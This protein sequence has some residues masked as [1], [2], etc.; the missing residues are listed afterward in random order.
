M[1][2][3]K[4]DWEGSRAYSRSIIL[5]VGVVV[6]SCWGWKPFLMFV[7]DPLGHSTSRLTVRRL[8]KEMGINNQARAIADKAEICE[9]H[10]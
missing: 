5:A 3:L 8:V 1:K 9:C 6:T 7:R 4:M 10:R 2:W